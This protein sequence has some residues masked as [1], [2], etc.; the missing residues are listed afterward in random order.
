MKQAAR[1]TTK[2]MRC[3]LDVLSKHTCANLRGALDSSHEL[4][5][6]GTIV[7]LAL[8]WMARRYRRQ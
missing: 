7:V 1:L 6:A 8:L 2:L 3:M 5:L 4:L